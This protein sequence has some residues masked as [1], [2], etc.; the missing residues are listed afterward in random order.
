MTLLISG[1]NQSGHCLLYHTSGTPTHRPPRVDVLYKILTY[2]S[3][4][5]SLLRSKLKD[6]WLVNKTI[7]WGQRSRDLVQGKEIRSG[8]NDWDSTVRSTIDRRP[9][10]DLL[11]MWCVRGS[12]TILA[13]TPG[14]DE[15]ATLDYCIWLIH[16]LPKRKVA[17]DV[18]QLLP[19][20]A[21]PKCILMV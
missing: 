14:E 12:W 21:K 11:R 2:Y 10:W 3:N 13:S 15:L 18:C 7:R 20:L 8:A 6:I 9:Q 17:K 19:C 4:I 5:C 16:S 1:W